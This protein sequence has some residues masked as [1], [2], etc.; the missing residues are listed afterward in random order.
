MVQMIM[1]NRLYETAQAALT[2]A[3]GA[4]GVA[5]KC[6][7]PEIVMDAVRLIAGHHAGQV[8]TTG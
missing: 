3:M 5:R 8:V 2:H 1:A 6:L 7:S 4:L